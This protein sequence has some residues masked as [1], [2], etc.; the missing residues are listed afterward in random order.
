MSDVETN[1]ARK[2]T[3]Q[4]KLQVALAFASVSEADFLKVLY[5][6][7]PKLVGECKLVS[8]L[9]DDAANA[10]LPHINPLI[11]GIKGGSNWPMPAQQPQ[12]G[13]AL[14][15]GSRQR[16]GWALRCRCGRAN[17]EM[18][19]GGNKMSDRPTPDI[20][21]PA[22]PWQGKLSHSR[23]PSD[24]WGTIRDERQNPIIRVPITLD[25][26]KLVEH[27]RAGTDPA[28]QIVD[29]ILNRIN[30]Y[31]ETKRKLDEAR[32]ALMK[33]EDLFI[34]GTDIYADRENMGIIARNALEG[35]K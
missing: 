10:A 6:L 30:A 5:A 28:Q 26:K 20:E 22:K 19:Q 24:D 13:V 34:D 21:S 29:E 35:A 16:M 2:D 17:S 18:G 14:P 11:D 33:I 15:Y 8:E 27:R 32:Q 4:K 7:A 3:P 9:S 23:G 1:A 12:T 25:E 31:E